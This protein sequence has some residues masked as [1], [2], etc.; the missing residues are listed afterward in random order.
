MTRAHVFNEVPR[1]LNGSAEEE[2]FSETALPPRPWTYPNKP[3][4]RVVAASR[5]TD[6][7]SWISILVRSVDKSAVGLFSKTA[8]D[9]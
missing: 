2:Y 1:N 6:M 5:T 8:C 7:D 9:S 3:N 4:Q